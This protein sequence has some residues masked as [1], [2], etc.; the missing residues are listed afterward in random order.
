VRGSLRPALVGADRR[1]DLHRTCPSLEG[2]FKSIPTASRRLRLLQGE[3][4]AR[5]GRDEFLV[6][7][8]A[9]FRKSQVGTHRLAATDRSLEVLAELVA[10][11]LSVH[12]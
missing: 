12:E 3:A 2:R 5:A 11:S 7:L 10:H 1:V 4:V 8:D 6:L 9:F